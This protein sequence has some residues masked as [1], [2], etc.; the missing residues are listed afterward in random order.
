MDIPSPV[1]AYFVHIVK[2]HMI[3][4]ISLPS[5]E[6][7]KHNRPRNCG[8]CSD[9]SSIFAPYMKSFLYFISVMLWALCT[10]LELGRSSP[11][12]LAGALANLTE[13]LVVLFIHSR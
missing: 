8:F 7:Y 12:V 2:E 4:Y 11:L 9:V 3:W 5:L 1:C 10:L 6:Y 13:V